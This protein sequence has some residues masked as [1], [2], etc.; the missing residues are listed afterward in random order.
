M[1][2][3]PVVATLLALLIEGADQVARAQEV[4]LHHARALELQPVID[5]YV[6]LD[7]GGPLVAR[8]HPHVAGSVRL[9]LGDDVRGGDEAEFAQDPLGLLE[10]KQVR[11]VPFAE[12]QLAGDEPLP[13]VDVHEVGE[14][15]RPAQDARLRRRPR[16][17]D[18][19]AFD[20]DA[21]DRS[22]LA[23][24]ILD[25]EL[26]TRRTCRPENSR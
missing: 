21:R 11:A 3:E 14:P 19:P 8:R 15:A 22:L 1:Q 6:D 12:Q 4:L 23:D 2:G 7:L 25:R 5:G 26:G 24:G 16:V 9:G 10:E 13:R 18:G 17:E 20:D